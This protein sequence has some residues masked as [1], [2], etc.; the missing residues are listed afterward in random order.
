MQ[1]R[2]QIEDLL[3]QGRPASW[4]P[5][6]LALA[7]LVAVVTYGIA[8]YDS[9][10][11]QVA[12]HYGPGGEAT[13]WEDK[14]P[15][16]VFL[17]LLMS[18]AGLFPLPIVAA[19]LPSFTTVPDDAS[20]WARMRIE[21]STRGTRS[22]LGWTAVLVVALVGG[23]SLQIWHGAEQIGTW[24][25]VLFML[26]MLPALWLA[27]RRWRRWARC[28]AGLHGI[29]PSSEEE[30]EDRLWLPLG[31]YNNPEDPR[32]FPPKREGYGVGTT[33][34][35]A[36]RGGRVFAVGLIAVIVVPIALIVWLG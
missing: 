28:T 26:A 31:I 16:T 6:L 30:A 5:F 10:P 32:V 8:I 36:T 11:E 17:P 12:M 19:V 33:V 9:I 22:G 4:T 24:P 14:S 23:L 25:I 35:V 2:D 3:R 7:L 20:D 13:R 1:T 21:G 34:N 29:H 27:Y 15:G 18:M